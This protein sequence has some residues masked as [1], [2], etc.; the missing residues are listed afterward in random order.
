MRKI[1]YKRYYADF[2]TTKPNKLNQVRVYIWALTSFNND[3]IEYGETI[4]SFV[5]YILKLKYSYI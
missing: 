1:N 3:L 5:E 2:E 4:E